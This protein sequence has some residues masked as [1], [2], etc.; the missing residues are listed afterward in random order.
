MDVTRF[1]IITD[2]RFPRQ[3]IRVPILL[4]NRLLT[5]LN[6]ELSAKVKFK[7]GQSAKGLSPIDVTE[8]GIV[9]FS[10]DLQ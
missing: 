5:I 2:V 8:S 4:I 3:A 7:L 9:T 10:R 6:G 1:G